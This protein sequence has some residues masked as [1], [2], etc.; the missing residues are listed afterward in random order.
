MGNVIQFGKASEGLTLMD[1]GISPSEVLR[2]ASNRLTDEI[3]P[4]AL[5]STEIRI[6]LFVFNR[7]AGSGIPCA[8][9]SGEEV[10]D[11][12]CVDRANAARAISRLLRK[13]FLYRIGGSRGE[14]GITCLIDYLAA[15]TLVPASPAIAS[16][17][18]RG[19][20]IYAL[21]NSAMPGVLKIG[22]TRRLPEDSAEELSRS[23]SAPAAFEVAHAVE[24]IDPIS[25]ERLIHELLSA[26]RVSLNR[27]F[28]RVTLDEF[29]AAADVVTAGGEA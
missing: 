8:R 25:A 9:F 24:V 26:S 10:A 27:E 1:N 28:F 15:G 18:E 21:S 16:V 6:L 2:L 14:I 11:A 4:A 20:F 23:T 7:T 22:M 13:G 17:R 5:S 3:L 12:I 29:I 19:G